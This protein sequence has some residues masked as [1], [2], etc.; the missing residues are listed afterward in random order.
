MNPGII[1]YNGFELGNLHFTPLILHPIFVCQPRRG[2]MGRYGLCVNFCINKRKPY[3]TSLFSRLS[4][5]PDTFISTSLSNASW[6]NPSWIL[7]P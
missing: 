6:Y 4:T 1:N 3:F 2:G 7:S 5:P